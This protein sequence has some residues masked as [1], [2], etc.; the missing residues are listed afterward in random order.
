M[1]VATFD[2]E[3][4]GILET[5]TKVWCIVIK[6]HNDGT[7]YEFGPNDIR[8][9]LRFLSQYSVLISHNG[10]AFDFPVLRKLYGWE[11][12][13]IKVDTL[14]MSRTQRPNR[15]APGEC[16]A[17]PHSVEAWG[18]RLGLGKVSND[19]WDRYSDN[20]LTRCKTDVEIQYKLYYALLKEGKGEGW[21][22]AHKLNF[23]LFDLLQRQEEYGW[24]VDKEH[25]GRCIR[26]LNRWM[27][28]IDKSVISRLPK[29]VDPLETKKN[30]EYGWVKKPFL[31]SGE[32]NARVREYYWD[33]VGC[34]IG[35]FSRINIRPV[36]IEST[37]EVKEFL[38]N[39][40]WTPKDWNTD[41]DGNRRSAK[42]SKDDPFEGINSGIGKLIAKRIQCRQRL[43]ILEGWQK[44]IRKD[45]RISPKVAGIASTG[46]LRHSVIVNVPSPHS[47]AFFAKQMRQ[48]FVAR[49][50]WTLVGVDSKGNQIRQLAARM[51]DEEFTTWAVKDKVRDGTDF[52]EYNMKLCGGIPR[53]R[54]KNF[55]YGFI[56][57][58]G[59]PKIAQQIKAS[60]KEARE[61]IELYLNQLPKLK[62]LINNLGA[63]WRFS[64]QSWFDYKTNRQIWANGKIKGVD[65]RPIY[66][67]SEHKILC[68]ALQ[69]DE[70]IQM[71]HAYVKF[72]DMMAEAGHKLGEDFG[73]V[74]WMH[75]EW[76]FECR[77]EISEA[78]AKIGCEAI[79]WA[80]RHL[81]IACPHEGDYKIGRN[82]FET[83]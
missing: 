21:K 41:D 62:E 56:F 48:C 29:V 71:G 49:P 14:L 63:E 77:P 10:I 37:L 55:F 54:A 44:A 16:N 15:R 22:A 12:N 32:Y 79:T 69:S 5:V 46:R 81:N 31:K 13:G 38:L 17:G 33:S 34:V 42:F 76:Q 19:V 72:H 24:L 36:D 30:G 6:D 80:G 27:A 83:H 68:Y 20:I 4:D 7:V 51:G 18:I 73:T 3:T 75:D 1:K 52:H 57:G 8:S 82:W 64:A 53:S 26:I 25:I 45:G 28:R 50:E 39:A 43:S 70:A 58:A 61:L 60:V 74:I 65:G 59:P 9:G 40:G 2:C 66:I 23:K 47:D 78:A 11:Y 35:P 67:D